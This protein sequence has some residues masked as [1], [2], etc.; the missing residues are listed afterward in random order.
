MKKGFQV[1]E[2]THFHL[3]LDIL[4]VPLSLIMT[5]YLRTFPKN[6]TIKPGI[7][8]DFPSFSRK[9]REKRG[10]GKISTTM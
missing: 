9:S 10:G 7:L 2:F 1:T 8:R 3:F 4:A 6:F 5:I